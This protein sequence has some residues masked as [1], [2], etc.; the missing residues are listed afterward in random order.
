MAIQRE[1][2]GGPWTTAHGIEWRAGLVSGG[3][4][5]PDGREHGAG[6]SIAEVLHLLG[7]RGYVRSFQPMATT[8]WCPSSETCF[9]PSTMVVESV[10]TVAGGTVLALRDRL[11]GAAGTWILVERSE[12]ARPML[13]RLTW[14]PSATPIQRPAGGAAA[15]TDRLAPFGRSA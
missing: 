7:R 1:V 15:P 9:D 14:S 13:A 12:W 8:L 6:I 3:P 2:K 5:A 10:T 11:S 4:S